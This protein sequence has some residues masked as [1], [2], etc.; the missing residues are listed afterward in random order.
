MPPL[1]SD[2]RIRLDDLRR[3][4]SQGRKF[5]MLTAYD[6]PTAQAAQAAGVHTLLVGDS[7]GTV[8]LGHDNT[9]RVPLSLMITLAEAVRRG[10]PSVYLVGDMPFEAM[11]SPDAVAR[12]ARRYRDEA[13]CDGVKLEVEARHADAVA[14]LAAEGFETIAH[15]GLRPQS[16]LTPDGYRAQARDEAAI[17]QLVEDAGRMVDAGAAMILLEAVPDQAAA[18]VVGAVDV[19]VIGCGAGP[20]CD[21]HVVVTQDMLGMTAIRPPR[22][23]PVYADLR[24]QIEAAMRRWVDE[25]DRGVYPGPEHVYGMRKPSASPTAK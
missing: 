4:K 18:A 3:F 16:V 2:S 25:I 14:R 7:M 6:F 1:D 19:P 13:G 8:L 24:E 15:L 11:A 12:A 23:V 20:S 5:S 21:G 9:R 10:A 17:E 22:F